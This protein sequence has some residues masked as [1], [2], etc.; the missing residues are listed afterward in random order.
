MTLTGKS[1]LL[2]SK[3]NQRYKDGFGEQNIVEMKCDIPIVGKESEHSGIIESWLEG[4]Q[5][6]YLC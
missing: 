6:V 1:T 4:L 5:W 3:L 2:G